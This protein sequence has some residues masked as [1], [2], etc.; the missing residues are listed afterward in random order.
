M[1]KNS[2]GFTLIEVMIVVAIIG[3][4]TAIAL[5]SYR[6]YLARGRRAE[7][8]AGLLQAAQWLERASTATG[9]YP[10]TAAFPPTL[11]AV[12]SGGYVISLVSPV[13]G[14]AGTFT[15]TATRA[16]PQLNDPCG[17]YSLNQAG[18][19]DATPLSGG[20]TVEDCWNR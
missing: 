15:L 18:V 5:P 10:A 14:I 7:A 3:I 4:L 2:H 16:A 13:G 20:R 19:R 6:E 9:Q 12:P 17:N 8:R 1:K 11:S